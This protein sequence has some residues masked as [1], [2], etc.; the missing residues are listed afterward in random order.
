M[1]VALKERKEETGLRTWK[2]L[3]G[4]ILSRG[5]FEFAC[6]VVVPS[7]LGHAPRDNGRSD[8]ALVG[9][10][11]CDLDAVATRR[12]SFCPRR[13][14][15]KK[16]GAYLHEAR[17]ILQ[18]F[19]RE[20]HPCNGTMIRPHQFHDLFNLFQ[21]KIVEALLDY[22][23]EA[24]EDEDECKRMIYRL[25]K[26]TGPG[27]GGEREGGSSTAVERRHS[28]ALR[29]GSGPGTGGF[30]TVVESRRRRCVWDEGGGLRR[31]WDGLVTSEKGEREEEQNNAS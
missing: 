3:S 10:G 8:L 4:W 19:C 1:E 18:E 25:C 11:G 23:E 31:S 14:C 22:C 24:Y 2:V 17:A 29:E 27:T 15:L 20:G 16:S 12:I 13:M 26:M 5:K 9:L 30:S 21:S 7:R 28:F 6:A